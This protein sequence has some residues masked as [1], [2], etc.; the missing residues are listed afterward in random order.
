M[1]NVYTSW[2]INLLADKMIEKITDCWKTPFNSPAVIFTD[3]KTEQWFKLRWLKKQSSGKGLLM[4]L[5]TL[6]IQQFLFD[7]VTPEKKIGQEFD[8][9]SVEL[10]RDLII[11]KLTSKSPDGTYYFQT[12]NSP[13]VTSYLL[14]NNATSKIN[15]N[16]LYDFAQ[17]VASLLL[18]Y[19]DTRPDNLKE[20]LSQ[21]A[22]QQKLY[23]DIIGE[24]GAEVRDTK[25]LT[26]F[27]LVKQNKKLNGGSISFNWNKE[28]P[29]FIFGFSGIGQIYRNILNDFSKDYQLEVY[30]QLAE[31]PAEPDNQLLSKWGD[32]GREQFELW[33]KNG[34]L[35]K[36]ASGDSFSRSDSLL[37][38]TQKAIQENTKLSQEPYDASDKSL[39][40]TAAPTRLREAE[41]LHS[42]ICKLLARDNNTQL[43]DILVVAPGI[44]DYKTVIEQVFDQNDQ[45]AGDTDFPYLPYTIADYSG[46]HSLTAEALS[47]LFGIHKKGYLSRSDLF[48]LL[49]NYLVQTVR[50]ISDEEVSDWADWAKALNIYR[51]RENH[52]EWQKAKKR[53]LLSRLTNDLVNNEI[54]PFESITSA[55]NESLYNFIQAIDEL[56]EWV[57][58]SKKEKFDK[59]DIDKLEEL[60]KNWLYLKDNVPDNFYNE[61]LVFQNVIEEIERQRN[62]AE[63][64]VFSDCFENAL[65]DRSNSVSLHSSNIFT[66][67][68]TFA[69]FE[70][71]RIL[72]AKYVFFMGLDSK[73]FPGLDS[74]NVLD[75]RKKEGSLPDRFPGDESIPERNK[76]A[77]ICQLMAAQEGLFFSYVNKNL[78]KDEDFYKAS[79]LCDLFQTLYIPG[80][81]KKGKPKLENE[82]YE[83]KIRIDEDRCWKEL[84]TPREFRNK[85]NYIQ[86]QK[87]ENQED[88]SEE[89]NNQLQENDSEKKVSENETVLPDRIS[90]WQLSD[91]LKEPFMHMVNQKLPDNFDN[92]EKEDLE[93]EPLFLGSRVTS[94]ICINYT[95]SGLTGQENEENQITNDTLKRDLSIDNSLPD[96]FFGD[97]AVSA[98]LSMARNML[99]KIEEKCP[100]ARSLAFND[101][102][103]QFIKHIPGITKKDFFVS[104]KYSWYNKD[105][106]SRKKIYAIEFSKYSGIL[107]AYVTSLLLLESIFNSNADEGTSTYDVVLY[108][109]GFNDKGSFFIKAEE[110]FQLTPKEAHSILNKIYKAMFDPPMETLPQKC[111]PMSLIKEDIARKKKDEALIDFSE[112]K[113]KLMYDQNNEWKYFSKKDFFNLDTDIGYSEAMFNIQWAEAKANQIDLIKFLAVTEENNNDAAETT[114]EAGE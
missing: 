19:E 12:L 50:G 102:I 62:T 57:A 85:K 84:Y 21:E 44:Q 83:E 95:R 86:L 104:G 11:T 98:S 61:S 101:K 92:Q 105:F 15:A 100:F 73:A 38:R 8:L 42:K 20:L 55:D 112:F 53:L 3:P 27:Q 97:Y 96:T 103:N 14:S 36:L 2:D 39:T 78:Q 6:R 32:F 9:L 69:N 110:D 77:F 34:Q 56:Q 7:L 4:N 52:E 75:L 24:S 71:N 1:K 28:T 81:D 59:N 114:E 72:S 106:N 109:A 35:E 10:L 49:H 70:S 17:T 29:V 76:N 63:P 26:L 65:F 113:T 45:F 108:T 37:H 64:D 43:G 30:L 94:D 33:S 99:E 67:G 90:I 88:D 16:H 25:Y 93:F 68:I 41:A 80:L 107:M 51:D 66:R 58:Y 22:W 74:D 54:L 46:D 40:L 47:I 31:I 82:E 5:K 60:L 48:A 111:I 23:S 13:E 91:F 87:S 18:D 89:Q 79:V